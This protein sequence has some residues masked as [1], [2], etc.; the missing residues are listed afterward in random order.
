M[1]KEEQIFERKDVKIGMSDGVYVEVLEGLKPEDK[2]K[3]NLQI[4]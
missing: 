1:D 4:K 3:G 2:V